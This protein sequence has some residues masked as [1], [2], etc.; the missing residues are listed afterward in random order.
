MVNYFILGNGSNLLVSDN[1]YNGVVIQINESN[2]SNFQV[3]KKKKEIIFLRLEEE[4]LWGL[5]Q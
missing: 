3:L 5:Y 4:C 2:F 1:G